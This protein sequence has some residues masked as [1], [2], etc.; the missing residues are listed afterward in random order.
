MAETHPN[1]L[2]GDRAGSGAECD[3]F[4]ASTLLYNMW[5]EMKQFF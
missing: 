3:A 2:G 1:H 5:Q 4:L